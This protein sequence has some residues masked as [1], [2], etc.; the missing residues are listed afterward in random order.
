MHEPWQRKKMQNG[1]TLVEL[2]F[3]VLILGII[4]G[5]TVVLFANLQRGSDVK[6]ISEDMIGILQLAQ[7]KTLSSN[8][9]SKYGVY[10]ET[11]TNPHQ[12]ILFKGNTFSTSDPNS[13]E[14]YKLP[15][16]VEISAINLGGGSEIAFDRL[17]GTLNP[18][19]SIAL[20][21]IAD[22]SLVQTIYIEDSGVVG[23]ASSSAPSDAN[24]TKDS[25][26]VHFTYDSILRPIDPATEKLVLTFATTTKE[27]LLT[28]NMQAGQIYWEGE[29]DDGGEI[30]QVKIHTHAFNDPVLGTRFS[31]HRDR[32]FNTK[33]LTIDIDGTV[34]P[35]PGTLI[36]YNANGQTSQGTSIYV[37]EPERQ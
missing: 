35:D 1:F 21:S 18:S 15:S 30:Q 19:G 36:Q 13:K 8:G 9:A 16:G 11:S 29:V 32:R 33:P 12:Y 22:P 20:R 25:R 10:F 6:R 5:M 26:H 37:S 7:S 24:R 3:F 28:Q 14:I 2:M 31:I 4:V 17:T 27:I 23:I 34:D